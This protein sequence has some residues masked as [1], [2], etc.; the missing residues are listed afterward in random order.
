M[1]EEHS[2][3]FSST[4]ICWEFQEID[5]I[6]RKKS[7]KAFIG[8]VIDGLYTVIE[9]NWI[10]NEP[11]STDSLWFT[12]VFSELLYS[13]TKFCFLNSFDQLTVNQGVISLIFWIQLRLIYVSM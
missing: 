10:N 11:I 6:I 5:Y 4:L 12:I 2:I 1:T 3:F 7:T 13:W 8:M 9:P